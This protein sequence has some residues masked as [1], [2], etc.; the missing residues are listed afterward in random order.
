MKLSTSHIC[1]NW[2]D[3]TPFSELC[4]YHLGQ[5]TW[6]WPNPYGPLNVGRRSDYTCVAWVSREGVL[7]LYRMGQLRLYCTCTT[8]LG[9]GQLHSSLYYIYHLPI[10]V[11]QYIWL[12]SI[13]YMSRTHFSM[14]IQWWCLFHDQTTLFGNYFRNVDMEHIIYVQ[15]SFFNMNSTMMFVL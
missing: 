14:W 3:F 9:W 7:Y 2:W 12:W 8:W 4:P 11:M 10:W 5:L 6:Q 15:D 13:S 1:I